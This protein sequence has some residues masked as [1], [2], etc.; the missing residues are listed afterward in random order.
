MK[1]LS[2][3]Q[4]ALIN[5]ALAEC[6][7]VA[8][9]LEERV[10]KFNAMLE[11]EKDKLEEVRSAYNDKLDELKGVY[12]ALGEEAQNY[13]DERSEAW[14][15]GDSGEAYSDWINELSNPDIEE[16][17]IEMPDEIEIELPDFTDTAWLPPEEPS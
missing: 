13:Y 16:L 8:G 9:F 12:E 5:A 2:K 11:E 1:K 15:Q 17:D 6:A 7:T 3:A 14:Q 10:G 4:L